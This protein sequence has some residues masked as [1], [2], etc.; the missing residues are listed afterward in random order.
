MADKKL[1]I[2]AKPEEEYI[3]FSVR[4]KI[5]TVKDLDEL[6]KKTN[7]S[8]NELINSCLQFAIENIEFEE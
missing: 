4:L 1:K 2:T 7:R 6:S 5:E 3:T 8:R